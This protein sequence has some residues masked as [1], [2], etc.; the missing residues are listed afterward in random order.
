MRD[1][2]AI[3]FPPYTARRGVFTDFYL[4]R[5]ARFGPISVCLTETRAIVTN[6]FQSRPAAHVAR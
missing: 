4:T 3:P 5:N 1:R 2:A 6:C